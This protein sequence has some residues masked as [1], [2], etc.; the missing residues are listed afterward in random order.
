M[1]IWPNRRRTVR[2]G[3]SLIEMLVVI[4][5]IGILASIVTGVAGN[6]RRS[7]REKRVRTKMEELVLLIESYKAEL[8][9]YPPDA[10][11]LSG[12]QVEMAPNGKP[13]VDPVFNPLFYELTGVLV[14]PQNGTYRCLL[15]ADSETIPAEV[16][17]TY[18]GRQ[19]FSNSARSDGDVKFNHAG[20][21]PNDIATISPRGGL[22]VEL[23]A[24]P[25]PWPSKFADDNP[26]G[27]G[28][29]NTWR[30]NASNPTKNPATFDLW[31]EYVE[32]VDAS[33]MPIIRRIGNWSAN[34]AN[35]Q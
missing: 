15:H 14:D 7:A 2:R 27:G 12:G 8:G 16:P 9:F 32:G 1:S 31:A 26:N 30:Y 22:E 33:G 17:E 23:L 19:G 28:T 21:Q 11:S 3:F 24:V 29:V 34:T 20:F 25:M 13:L 5:V 35:A 6:A 10:Q 18:F 4:V